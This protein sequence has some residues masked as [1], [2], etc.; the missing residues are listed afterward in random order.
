MFAKGDW[1]ELVVFATDLLKGLF[2]GGDF[3]TNL[4]ITLG[5]LALLAL[6]L[7]IYGLVFHRKNEEP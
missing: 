7:L 2:R 3:W 6:A 5:F 4:Y 1:L